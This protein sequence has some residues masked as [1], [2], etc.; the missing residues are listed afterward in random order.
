MS[1][2]S[3]TCRLL[4]SLGMRFDVNVPPSSLAEATKL[5]DQCPDTRFVLDHCGNADPVAFFPAGRAAPRPPQHSPESWK[6][7]MACWPRRRTSSARSRGSCPGPGLPAGRRRRGPDHQPLPRRLRARSRDLRERLACV[8][9]GHAAA[10]LGRAPAGS[11][12]RPAGA[13]QAEAVPRQ[14]GQRSTVS[15]STGV[16]PVGPGPR[17]PWDSW[18]RCPCYLSFFRAG[19]GPDCFHVVLDPFASTHAREMTLDCQPALLD[20]FYRGSVVAR[21]VDKHGLAGT[22]AEGVAS[23]IGPAYA[24]AMQGPIR[25]AFAP[26]RPVTYPSTWPSRYKTRVMSGDSSN[27]RASIFSRGVA[28]IR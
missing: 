15:R 20:D 9:A 13:G 12:R 11:D 24:V 6:R 2:R 7:D 10:Q 5:V 25:V 18:A 3:G 27:S 1:G 26:R 19:A 28:V 4:G 8:P 14:C 16:S 21:N 22:A 23:R 17:W